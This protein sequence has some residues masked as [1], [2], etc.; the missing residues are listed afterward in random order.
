VEERLMPSTSTPIFRVQLWPKV[1][2]DIE[3]ESNKSLYDL[4]AAIV[5]AFDF[6]LDHA[7][8]FFSKLDDYI[9]DPPVCYELLADLDGDSKAQSVK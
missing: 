4:A 2:R 3:I 5:Q 7:F 8:G 9:F 1:D 6:E